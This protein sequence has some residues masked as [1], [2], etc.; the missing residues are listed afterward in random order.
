MAIVKVV[1]NNTGETKEWTTD[2]E[3]RSEVQQER[4]TR[5]TDKQA[6]SATQSES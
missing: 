1:D 6:A 2:E 3:V 5:K 4:K